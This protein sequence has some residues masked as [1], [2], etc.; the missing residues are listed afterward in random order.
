MPRSL[1]E[2][3]SYYLITLTPFFSKK[4]MRAIF[5]LFYPGA[6]PSFSPWAPKSKSKNSE[7]TG[8]CC[9]FCSVSPT[10]SHHC[11]NDEN[12][13]CSWRTSSGHVCLSVQF[14]DTLEGLCKKIKQEGPVIDPCDSDAREA[15][16]GRSLGC[17]SQPV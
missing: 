3:L 14:Q 15:K 7:R 16:T 1:A 17:A 12:L 4:K 2:K 13:L 5:S 6:L 10:R 8:M 11:A 9:D